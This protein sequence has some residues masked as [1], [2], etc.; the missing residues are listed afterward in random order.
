VADHS[1]AHPVPNNTAAHRAS[2]D[3]AD[4]VSYTA[5]NP[6]PDAVSHSPA[7]PYSNRAANHQCAHHLPYHSRADRAPDHPPYSVPD[8]A[9]VS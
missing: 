1:D 7:D 4:A 3:A 8:G 9:A 2:H 5:T 6:A